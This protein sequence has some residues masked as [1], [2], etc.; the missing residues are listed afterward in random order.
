MPPYPSFRSDCNAA[1]PIPSGI[2][3]LVVKLATLHQPEDSKR[4]SQPA[5]GQTTFSNMSKKPTDPDSVKKTGLS[6]DLTYE[7]A[8]QQLEEILETLE[9]GD[10]PLEESL[11]LYERGSALAAYCTSKLDEA[12]LRVTQWQPDGNTAPFEDWQDK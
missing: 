9:T 12:E 8:Y 5:R 7:E 11:A 10:L 1:T 3:I 6:E 4:E 2:L